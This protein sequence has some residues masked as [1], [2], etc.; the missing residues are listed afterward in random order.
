MVARPPTTPPTRL[1]DVVPQTNDQRV[2]AV[3]LELIPKLIED[4]VELGQVP[5]PDGCGGRKRRR[6]VREE[7]GPG[8]GGKCEAAIRS[9]QEERRS[10]PFRNC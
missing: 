8:C 4:L 5:S 6:C 10:R 7:K 1:D 3:G 9:I 2:G